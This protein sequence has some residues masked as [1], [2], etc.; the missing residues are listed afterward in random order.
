MKRYQKR[1]LAKISLEILKG[2]VAGGFII[3]AF[4]LPNIAQIIKIFKPNREYERQKIKRAIDSLHRYGLI[5]VTPG[6]SIF[7]K[8]VRLTLAGKELAELVSFALPRPKKWDGK[9]RIVAFD[10]PEPHWK[11]RRALSVKLRELGC[12]H[13]Q[14]SV[15]VYP[16]DC[17]KEVNF[18]RDYFGLDSSIKYMVAEKIDDVECLEDFFKL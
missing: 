4:A 9:W 17:E 12:Y 10:V 7:E 11:A 6:K 2:F 3:A 1:R 15:F 16:Y 8:K 18:I 13:Y 5:S 14:N